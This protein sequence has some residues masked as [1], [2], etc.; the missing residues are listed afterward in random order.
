MSTNTLTSARKQHYLK[1]FEVKLHDTLIMN[2]VANDI[3]S[4]FPDGLTFNMP[5]LADMAVGNY[6]GT[7]TPKNVTTANSTLTMDKKP[8]VTFNYEDTDKKLDSWDVIG[9]AD[10][11][12]VYKIKQQMESDFMGQYASARYSNATPTS[13]LT[14]STAYST[15]SYAVSTLINAGVPENEICIIG[16]AYDYDIIAQQAISSTFALSDSSF[17]RG[18]VGAKLAGAML[19]RNQNLTNT[20]VLDIAT[21]P[22][23]TDTIVIN[24]V[25]F[26]FVSTIGT[27]AGNILIETN[28]ATTAAY[29][30]EAIN[31][32]ATGVPWANVGVKYVAFTDDT[33]ND[34]LYGL[35]AAVVGTTVTLVSKHGYR[36][37]SSNMTNASNDWQ[38]V[39]EH[40]LVMGRG[41]FTVAYRAGIQNK[42][43][44]I[45]NTLQDQYTNWL[46]WGQ[47]VSLEGAKRAFNLTIMKQAAEL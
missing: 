10:Q 38:A 33:A 25:T 26:T 43:V 30:V 20:T 46:F 14:T 18:Y 32:A 37:V 29:L 35:T 44:P 28:A 31:A 42:V 5:Q 45:Y 40:A 47:T 23:A 3:S 22:T 13:V 9:S 16:D 1:N 8:Y 7:L 27:T 11:R 41:A 24:G 19:Y 36:I 2:D 6:T 15:F 34:F 4:Q 21:Q 17:E 39:Y 12:A